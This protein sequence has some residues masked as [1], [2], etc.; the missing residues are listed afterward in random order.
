MKNF[1]NIYTLLVMALVG[2]SL[3]ACSNDDLDTDQFQGGVA[4]NVYGPSPVMRGGQLRFIGSNLDQVREV[5]IPS[6]IHI[7]NIQVVSAGVP[8]EIRITVPK[9]GPVEGLV[10]LVTNSDQ[11]ITTKTPLKYEE[12]IEITKMTASAMPGDVIKIEGDYLN[13]IHSLAFA[14]N[15]LI[16]EADFVSHDR[17]AIEVKV[18]EEAKTGKLELY[19]ADLTVI[20]KNSVE[21]QII[22]TDDAIEIGVPAIE[23]VKGRQEA[24]AQGAITAKAGEQISIT[25]AYFNVAASVTVGGFTTTDIKASAD[26]KTLTFNLPAEAPSGEII[27]VCKSGVEVPVGT[28]TTVK[29]TE[30]VA[31]PNPVKAGQAL[32]ISGQDM[33]LVTAVTFPAGDATVEG[34]E[35][36]VT[37]TSVVVKAVPEKATAGN[38]KLVMANAETVDV[39]FTLVMPT[40]TAYNVNPASAGSPLQISGT[41]LDLVKSITFGEAE[42]KLEEGA[43]SADGK[44]I[45]VTIPMAGQ[46]GKPK[47][48]LANGT[49][50]EGLDLTINE[51]VFC[52]FTELPAEDAEL[53]A[54]E[55]FMLPVANV[56]KLTG[57]EINGEACQYVVSGGNNLIVGIPLTAKKGSSVRLISSNGEITYT[58]DFI[59]NTEV[60]TV[61]WTGTADVDDWANQPY[62]LS[63]G[64]Q[65]LKDAG[66]EVGDIITFHLSPKSADWKIQFVEG[67]WGPTYASICSIGNDTESGKF[68]EYDLEANKGNFSLEVT[69]EMLDAAYK[70]GGW[71]GV[72]VLNGDNLIVDKITTTHFNSLET[73]LWEGEAVADNWGGQPYIL[74]D[75]GTELLA[76][77]MK[78]GSI[79]RCYLKLVEGETTWN[80]QIVDGHWSPNTAFDGCDFNSDNWNLSEHNGAIEFT[81]TDYIYEHITTSGGWGGSFLLNG[82]NVICTKVTIE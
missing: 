35:I 69:Q 65:E 32:T 43:V 23:K 20:D 25:G 41:D 24:A 81:V 4:L 50:V 14:D 59:P 6:D 40:I 18:P 77:G 61:L 55:S 33:D 66:V 75:G 7:T 60:T 47:F 16:S 71:G 56:D 45:T 51:A 70:V 31:A 68:T 12:G 64:G 38:L 1:K 46:S 53:K 2:L 44:K 13:L 67:H 49:S 3:T 10:T 62:V 36:T 19:T 30:A 15:V 76:A 21:Y 54:G 42:A 72:F 34:G 11:R 73:T 26:G 58:F 52:Y 8:S 27:I 39:A 9:D 63:D 57:V 28:L 22:K 5:I 17:Y 78:V 37:A 79:I 82:D 29:P 74:S 80:C 48:N